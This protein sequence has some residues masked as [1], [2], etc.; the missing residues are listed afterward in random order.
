M[1]S[2]CQYVCRGIFVGMLV[3]MYVHMSMYIV[4]VCVCVC[5]HVVRVWINV[6]ACGC[7][8]KCICIYVKVWQCVQVYMWIRMCDC[9]CTRPLLGM[10][11]HG[12]HEYEKG[13]VTWEPCTRAQ[14]VRAWR[15]AFKFSTF[16]CSQQYIHIHVNKLYPYIYIIK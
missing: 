14:L 10:L 1:M 5:V 4:C 15:G 8:C 16:E 12:N 7:A 11:F 6:N 2:M 3:L 13:W 9:V